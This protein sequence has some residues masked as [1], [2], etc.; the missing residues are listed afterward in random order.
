MLTGLFAYWSELFKIIL[1]VLSAAW[2]HC[3]L[4]RLMYVCESP[5]VMCCHSHLSK[6][7]AVFIEER[8]CY[9]I[10]NDILHFPIAVNGMLCGR[11]QLF[12][13]LVARKSHSGMCHQRYSLQVRRLHLATDSTLWGSTSMCVD[14]VSIY[15]KQSSRLDLWSIGMSI[16]LF[17]TYWYSPKRN[18][19]RAVSLRAVS[20]SKW[21]VSLFL[22]PR[23]KSNG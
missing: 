21:L 5:R 1:N 3:L 6:I 15:H 13:K 8:G 9:S 19:L 11:P 20:V 16:L 22:S 12:R 18:C 7:V 14:L 17:R 10:T 4:C 2:T 23:L